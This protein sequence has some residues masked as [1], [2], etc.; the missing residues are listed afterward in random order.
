MSMMGRME[1]FLSLLAAVDGNLMNLTDL[2][3]GCCDVTE[4]VDIFIYTS[5]NYQQ[6]IAK[7][8]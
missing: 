2:L 3:S 5:Y 6:N 8:T 1:K 7:T 4:L